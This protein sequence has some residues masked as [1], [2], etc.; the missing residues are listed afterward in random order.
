M[1]PSAA[2]TIP[3]MAPSRRNRPIIWRPFIP[4]RGQHT[5]LARALENRHHHQVQDADAGDHHHDQT[6]D[7]CELAFYLQRL[8]DLRPERLPRI[9]F[10]VL[11]L[12]LE[13]FN[14]LVFIAHGVR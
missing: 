10:I 5:H 2:P 7:G 9:D 13:V 8:A 6:K 11:Q 4:K 1:Q 12:Y 14:Q 3:I